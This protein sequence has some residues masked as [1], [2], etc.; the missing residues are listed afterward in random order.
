MTAPT[1]AQ[2]KEHIYKWRE[3]NKNKYNELSAK[4]MI[5]YRLWKKIRFE[6]FNILIL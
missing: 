5:K 3:Q 2:N 6:F 1:Y 4:S